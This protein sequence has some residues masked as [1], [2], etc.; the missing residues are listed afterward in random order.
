MDAAPKGPVG[1][2]AKRFQT[3]R[4]VHTPIGMPRACLRLHLLEGLGAAYMMAREVSVAPEMQS[5]SLPSTIIYGSCSMTPIPC[6][7]PY[8]KTPA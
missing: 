6:H 1:R 3:G 2:S 7:L 8:T 5:M 4:A